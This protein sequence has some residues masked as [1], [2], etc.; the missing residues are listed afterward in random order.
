MKLDKLSWS[1]LVR[2][3]QEKQ[4]SLADYLLERSAAQA[5]LEPAQLLEE[6]AARLKVME[7][8][9]AFGLTGVRSNSGL[10]GGSAKKM[11]AYENAQK[12]QNP[13]D[14]WDR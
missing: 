6:M 2:E 10:T 8:A 4:L 14:Y 7:D 13:P 9:V 1:D 3:A 12:E 5:E 11:A